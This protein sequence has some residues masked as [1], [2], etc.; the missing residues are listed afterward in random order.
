MYRIS[1][2]YCGGHPP[3]LTEEDL[4]SNDENPL[5]KDFYIY[6]DGGWD[7]DISYHDEEYA[8]IEV[9]DELYNKS[10]DI[11]FFT[12]KIADL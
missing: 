12:K 11:Q 1:S 3:D 4:K 8:I 10:K 7:F 5:Q 2:S 9:T 6:M